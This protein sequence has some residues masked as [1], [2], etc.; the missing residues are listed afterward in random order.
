MSNGNTWRMKEERTRPMPRVESLW[1][2]KNGRVWKVAEVTRS[3]VAAKSNGFRRVY[4]LG[5]WVEQ[6]EPFGDAELEERLE[7]VG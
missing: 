4:G 1:S 7:L 2:D 3:N 5:T 6:F